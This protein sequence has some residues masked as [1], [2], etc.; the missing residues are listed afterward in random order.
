MSRWLVIAGVAMSLVGLVLVPLP[1]PGYPVLI[2]GVVL[3][4]LGLLSHLS[5]RGARATDA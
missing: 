4:I 3:V 5:T 1:G 2:G